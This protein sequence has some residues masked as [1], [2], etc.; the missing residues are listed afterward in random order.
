MLCLEG[1]SVVVVPANNPP[2]QL[3][4]DVYGLR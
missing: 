4:R 1:M 3:G 2:T